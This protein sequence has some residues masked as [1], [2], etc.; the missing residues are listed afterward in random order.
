MLSTRLE[1]II[2]LLTK[3][4]CSK[5]AEVQACDVKD[6]LIE[7][8]YNLD[9]FEE[10]CQRGEYVLCYVFSNQKCFEPSTHPLVCGRE[11]Y[12]IEYPHM[13]EPVWC[14]AS[15][16]LQAHWEEMQDWLK[17]QSKLQGGSAKPSDWKWDCTDFI[18]RYFDEY[19]FSLNLLTE[20]EI[21]EGIHNW[22]Y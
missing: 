9:N 5:N 11:R 13:K 7:A 18:T 14:L 19:E 4:I 8:A 12:S 6:A 10:G 1:V 3:K 22:E 20:Q 15:E 2:D 21:Q 17:A 16:I